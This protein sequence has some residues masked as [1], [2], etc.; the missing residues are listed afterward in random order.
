[1]GSDYV[2]TDALLIAMLIEGGDLGA[3]I[4]NDL[5]ATL[6]SVRHELEVMG[7]PEPE[8]HRKPE[9]TAGGLYPAERFSNNAKR[10]LA[11]AQEE[12]DSYSHS[13]IGTEHLLLGLLGVT[14]GTASQLLGKLG[15]DGGRVRRAIEGVLGRSEPRIVI[16]QIT[17]TSRVKKVIELALDEAHRTHRP[18]AG[19]ADLLNALLI[20]GEGIAAHILEDFGVTVVKVRTQVEVI[21]L[22]ASD[23]PASS[24]SLP[25]TDGVHKMLAAADRKART[26]GQAS[27]TTEHVLLGLLHDPTATATLVLKELGVAEE[28]RSRLTAI[29][30]P[31]G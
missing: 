23:N 30:S 21:G 1:M 8:G 22:E 28:V 17:P 6:P 15:V 25:L 19:T 27:V 13:Y 2:D 18:H 10:V 16:H 3:Q 26:F 4:L 9:P 5:G 14:E 7:P 29:L 20:E 12:A 24:Q 31:E 11:L